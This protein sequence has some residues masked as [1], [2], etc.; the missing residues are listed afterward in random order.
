VRYEATSQL[1]H[2]ALKILSPFSACLLNFLTT[3]YL[4]K[5]AQY[6]FP[7]SVTNA[8]KLLGCEFCNLN[9]FYNTVNV[10]L[11]HLLSNM[12]LGCNFLKRTSLLCWNIQS[13]K[14]Q[15]FYILS[16]RLEQKLPPFSNFVSTFYHFR[17]FNTTLC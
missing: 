3:I 16:L 4:E 13:Y 15:K 9:Y 14:P 17:H 1:W 10:P 12:I 11:C 8:I 5:E 7:S 2:A 6:V